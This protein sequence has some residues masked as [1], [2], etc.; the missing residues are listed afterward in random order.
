M[1]NIAELTSFFRRIPFNQFFT[2]E[3][4]CTVK[5]VVGLISYAITVSFSA[6]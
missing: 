3:L 1:W 6:F 5:L 4:Q 2:T